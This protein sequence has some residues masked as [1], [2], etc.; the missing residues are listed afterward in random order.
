MVDQA[1]KVA[2]VILSDDPAR[3]IPGLV[4]AG[5]MKENRGADVRLLFFGP[6]VRLAASGEADEHLA[7]LRRVGVVP[8][9]CQANV[10]QYELDEQIGARPIELLAAGAEIESY[11]LEG[12][13]VVSF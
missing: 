9:A 5:R 1:A 11:A 8:T 2:F 12:Y 10:A 7:T 4:L 13:T 3:A 6:G